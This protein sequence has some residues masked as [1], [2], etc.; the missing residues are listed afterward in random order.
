[1]SSPYRSPPPPPTLLQ[2]R[3]RLR[4]A[5]SELRRAQAGRAQAIRQARQ[6]E[7]DLHEEM[8]LSAGDFRL[9]DPA[10]RNAYQLTRQALQDANSQE[11]TARRQ[12]EQLYREY[13]QVQIAQRSTRGR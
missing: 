1:V 2:T 6:A 13:R 8:R 11:Q 10:A 5:I 7:Q 3:N 12:F 9:I 4:F